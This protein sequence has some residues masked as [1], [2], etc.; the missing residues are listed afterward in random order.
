MSSAQPYSRRALHD[1]YG[2]WLRARWR[3]ITGTVLG[4]VAVAAAVTVWVAFVVSGALRWYALGVVHAVVLGTALHL[5]W[6]VFL[7]HDARAIHHLRGAWG[8][9]NTRDELRRARRRRLVWGWVDSVE[10]EGGD[11]DHL[12]VTRHAGVLAID[13]KWRS[14]FDPRECADM[15]RAASTARTRAQ[16]IANTY[17]RRERGAHRARVNPHQVR[18]VV[19]LWGSA[20]HEL[21]GAWEFEG[22]TFVPGRHLLTWLRGLDGETVDKCAA[23]D[24]LEQLETFRH[25]REIDVLRRAHAARAAR[26]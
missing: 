13:S 19:V 4:V 12:V 9:D 20:Q 25:Q 22:V 16:G 6:M 17:L 14:A 23:Q 26:G 1:S 18:P 3:L 7:A 24:L 15:A 11:I 10:L 2:S 5:L 21:Q 8:E